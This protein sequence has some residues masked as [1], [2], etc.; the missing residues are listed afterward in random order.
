M[1]LGVCVCGWWVDMG[2]VEKDPV[3]TLI[4]YTV[5]MHA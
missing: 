3:V 4:I 5:H 2:A 1:G